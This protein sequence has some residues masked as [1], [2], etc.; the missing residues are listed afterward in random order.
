MT[1]QGAGSSRLIPHKELMMSKLTPFDVTS[2]DFLASPYSYYARLHEG[3]LIFH[4]AKV[5]AYFVG[6]YADVHRILT[7]SVFTTAPVGKRV[8]PVMHDR[9]LAQM[10][11]D[12]HAGKRRIVSRG[13]HGKA[14]RERTG[15][16]VRK[17]T[18]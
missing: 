8:E 15:M 7:S 12:E 11:G 5:N 13:L 16:L 3:N 17:H 6:K 9:V 1:V 18:E 14:F 2:S 10:E 4:D